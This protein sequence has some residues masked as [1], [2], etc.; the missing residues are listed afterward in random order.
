MPPALLKVTNL[1]KYFRSAAGLFGKNTRVVKAVDDVSLEVFPSETLGLVGESGCGKSTLGRCILRL[2][3]PTE[4]KVEFDGQDLL[5]LDSSHLR[6]KRRDMQIIFQDPYSSLNPRMRIGTAVEEPLIIHKLAQKP[7]RRRIIS[8]LLE[9]VGLQP[10]DASRY[11][12]EFSGGQRQR[13][14]IARA[15]ASNPKFIVADEPVSSLDVSIQA[16]IVN[17]LGELQKTFQLAFLFISHGLPVIRHI[18][19]RVS[20]M[21]LG[22]IVEEAPTAELFENPLHPYTKLLL[23]AVPE[24]DPDA[25]KE[26]ASREAGQEALDIPSA[27]NPPPGCRFHTRC[28]EVMDKCRQWEPELVE[29]RPGHKVACF[30][31]HDTVKK[32]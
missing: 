29:L 15:L 27:S 20:V 30:L 22:K 18:C 4:G 7:Q 2:I 3:E 11:P 5:A 6:R 12:H 31:H 32:A 13:I 24:P 1:K 9:L 23:A 10:Q 25:R 28:P 26:V 19:H 16:Q 17:L 21:Y 14:G 8:D